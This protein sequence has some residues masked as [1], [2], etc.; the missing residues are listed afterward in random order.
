MNTVRVRLISILSFFAVIALALGVFFGMFMPTKRAD[1]AQY[2]PSAVFAS[3]GTSGSVGASEA[4][5]GET[6]YIRFTF[7]DGGSTYFRRDLALRW[8]EAAP[9]SEEDPAPAATTQRANP[10]VTKY[11]SMTFAFPE[12]NFETFEIVF[13]STEENITE[14]GKATNALVFFNENGKLSV[15]VKDSALEDAENSTLTQKH[16]IQDAAADIAIAITEEGCNHGEFKV[17]LGGTEIGK[18]TNIGGYFLEYRSQSSSSPNT[19]ITFTAHL[20][21][22]ATAQQQV[23][24]KELNGQTFALTDGQ[25]TDNAS[26]VLVLNKTLHAFRLGSRFNLTYEAIDVCRDTVTV[27]RSYYMLKKND[28]GK[29]VTPN[30]ETDDDY[31]SLST[32]DYFLPPAEANDSQEEY[33]SIR[34]R[35]NDS[36]TDPVYTYLTWYTADSDVAT[37]GEEGQEFDYIK[38]NREQEGPNYI[39]LSPAD[40]NT[41]AE[42]QQVNVTDDAA[43]TEWLNGAVAAYQTELDNAAKELSAGS[44]AYIYLPSMR[45]LFASEHADY[46]DLTFSIYYYKPTA[47]AGDTA[48]AATS[49]S[50]NGLRLEINEMG[51]YKMRVLAT[52]SA[53]NGINLW[54]D[55]EYTQ[56]TSNNIWDIEEIPEFTFYI[57]YTGATIEEP[58]EQEE[59]YRD[60]H[61]SFEQFDVIALSGYDTEY[62]LYYFDLSEMPEGAAAPEY[63]DF[64]KGLKDYMTK[65]EYAGCRREIQEY[66]S[67]YTEDDPAWDRTDNDYRWDPSALSFT[68]QE[69]GFYVLQVVVTDARLPGHTATEYQATYVRNPIDTIPGSS[70]WLQNNVTSVV[71]FSIAGV[72][73]I[74]IVVLIVV[75]PARVEVE[76]VDLKKLKGAPKKK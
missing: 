25:V 20:P 75:K 57:G 11:F 58:G 66:Q 4:E 31:K 45:G 55:G 61:Y 3:G 13:E 46:R 39:G 73:A 44:G 21:E 17:T 68:P 35:L 36:T 14:K 22:G 26:P 42:D 51:T 70:Q 27:T 63:A 34:L 74:A 18:F 67:Q 69:A 60:S 6:S 9:V 76:E 5:E 53:G 62:K 50:Y 10:S 12:V 40:E 23:L 32:S 48:S 64:V 30:E 71:L 72:L 54:V 7:T 47:S 28:E 38:V 59:G 19:P 1:A 49:L 24:M 65:E 56:V 37:L 29:Y 15:A 16:E 2:A 8:Q 41:A 43:Y 52:D 33:V